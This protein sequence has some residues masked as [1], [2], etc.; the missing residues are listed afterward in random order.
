MMSQSR[1]PDH[2]IVIF[3]SKFGNT[4]KIA[5]SLASGLGL[6]GVRTECI[7]AGDVQVDS[8]TEYDLIAIGAPTQAFTAS[9]PMKDF[10]QKLQ[11]VQSLEGKYG[12]AFDTKFRGRIAGSGAGFIEKRL[13]ELGMKIIRPRQSAIVKKTEGPLEEGEEQAFERI[14]FEIGSALTKDLETVPRIP[15]RQ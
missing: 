3:D 1:T 12:F 2:G 9:R 8:L 11:G 6:A 14:G 5:K 4:E 10:L 7:H 13:T 15:V